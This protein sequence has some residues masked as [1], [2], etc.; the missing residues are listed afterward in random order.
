[1]DSKK[2]NTNKGH[3]LVK[4]NNKSTKMTK[5]S[6]SMFDCQYHLKKKLQQTEK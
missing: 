2:E 4:E 5:K 1:M 6:I 3:I